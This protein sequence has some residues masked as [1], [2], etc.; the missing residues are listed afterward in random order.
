MRMVVIQRIVMPQTPTRRPVDL[1][2][3]R[4]LY[5][6]YNE[7]SQ[8]ERVSKMRI[9]IEGGAITAVIIWVR[10]ATRWSTGSGV[11]RACTQCETKREYSYGDISGEPVPEVGAAIDGPK[12]RQQ[13]EE[14]AER[15]EEEK[16]AKEGGGGAGPNARSRELGPF[17]DGW[18]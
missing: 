17:S 3:C 8:Q 9:H 7:A 5:P 2:T 1:S 14:P 12:K 15:K 10:C 6:Y 11:Y 18:G 13:A 4:I 16:S